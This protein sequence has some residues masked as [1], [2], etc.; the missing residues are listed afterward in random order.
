M[1]KPDGS[2]SKRS[3]LGLAIAT[4]EEWEEM[5]KDSLGKRLKSD[6]GQPPL[7]FEEP[8]KIERLLTDNPNLENI[9]DI[10]R[11]ESH[12]YFQSENE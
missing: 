2:I 11:E 1:E 4:K 9:V 7:M 6:D 3:F 10:V 5:K 8:K 12:K